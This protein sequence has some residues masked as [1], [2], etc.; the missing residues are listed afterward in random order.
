MR[1]RN[2]ALI[3]SVYEA[4]GARLVAWYADPTTSSSG[5]QVGDVPRNT[6]STQGAEAVPLLWF[7][8][9]KLTVPVAPAVADVGALTEVTARSGKTGP[10]GGGGGGGG[11]A[12]KVNSSEVDVA[13]VPAG[14]VTVMSTVPA[15]SG[16]EMAVTCV[17]EYTVKD[18]AATDPKSTAV[19]PRKFVPVIVTE[20][21]PLVDPETGETPVTVGGAPVWKVNRSAEDVALVPPDGVVTVTSTIPAASG[22][23][24]AVTCVD[25]ST[26]KEAAGVVPKSTA[27]APVKSYPLMV[28]EAPPAVDPYDGD[29][30]VTEGA[31]VYVNVSAGDVKLVPPDGVVTVT[32]TIPAAS[33]G[34]V[35]VTCVDESTVKEAAGVVPK[36]T[37]AA[38][39]RLLPFTT[40]VAPPAVEPEDGLAAVTATCVPGPPVR[41]RACSVA[42]TPLAAS[43]AATH[44]VAVA[45]AIAARSF[46]CPDEVSWLGAMPHAV[47][48]QNSTKL[49]SAV[50]VDAWPTAT[51]AYWL[52]HVIEPS[53]LAS[54]DEV[55]GLG[56]IDHD[57]PSHDMTSV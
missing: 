14:V 11:G 42:P 35:A 23:E 5:L 38:P 22:G 27:A 1:G 9:V 25:E 20:V 32:S 33:G 21:L 6:V 15:A 10:G 18:A 8:T 45:H 39:V 19:A 48:P 55:S 56:R 29:T 28:T 12:V 7:S 46:A 43:P 16:G 4:Y 53:S 3:D 2:G 34:E 57:M 31:L 41:A 24:V 37:A 26:V 54:L 13:L 17:P 44:E 52:V 36:S 40:T 51:H 47:P 50:A 49:T 30:P